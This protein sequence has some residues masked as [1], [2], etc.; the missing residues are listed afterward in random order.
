MRNFLLHGWELTLRHKYVLVVL[1]LYRLLWGFFLYRFIDSV[2]SPVLARFPDDHPNP[3]AVRMF[4]IE[5][6]FRLFKTDI[7]FEAL[8]LLAGMFLIRMIATPLINAGLFYSFRHSE[9]ARGTKVL[10]GIRR[11]WKGVTALYWI[12]SALTLAPLAWLVPKGYSMYL[13]EPAL[14]AWLQNLLP[15]VLGWI[16][17]S[18]AVH[19]LFQFMQFSSASDDPV[20][21]GLLRACRRAVPLALVTLTLLGIS[22]LASA[23]VTTAGFLWTGFAAVALHQAFQLVRSLLSLWISASQFEVWR[24]EL[25][26]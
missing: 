20:L 5:A 17:W 23:V 12:E 10:T 25:S 24:P 3:D 7:S 11:S 9:D 15:Y 6:Q 1:F 2:V 18:F 19:L 13:K 8:A 26:S 22:L 21:Q 4:F 16:I 14:G